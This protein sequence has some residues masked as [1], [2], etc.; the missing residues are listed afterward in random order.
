[1]G[2]LAEVRVPFFVRDASQEK[3]PL[4]R[5]EVWKRLL[6]E[7]PVIEDADIKVRDRKI[8]SAGDFGEDGSTSNFHN[9][10]H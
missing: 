1:M 2:I 8:H 5:S 6:D 4:T 3:L 10:N 7:F 9:E